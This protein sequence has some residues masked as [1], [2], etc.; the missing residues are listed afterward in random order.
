MNWNDI[1]K[2]YSEWK[3]NP[4][5]YTWCEY[6]NTYWIKQKWSRESKQR[7]YKRNDDII[8]KSVSTVRNTKEVEY[9][10]IGIENGD[11]LYLD[12]QYL[13]LKT[14]DTGYKSDLSVDY[15]RPF[16]FLTMWVDDDMNLVEDLPNLI[17]DADF[18]I[19]IKG[20]LILNYG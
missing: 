18:K 11:L 13:K 10:I 8:Y 15:I 9:A 6:Y 16:A 7:N 1:L 20:N 2:L 5:G 12:G 4:Q 14:N 3:K 17:L 19:D